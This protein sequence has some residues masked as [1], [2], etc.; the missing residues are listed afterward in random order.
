MLLKFTIKFFQSFKL[1]TKN[2]S[3]FIIW[4]KSIVTLAWGF[5]LYAMFVSES[6]LNF[7]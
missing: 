2:S 1:V 7:I 3:D 5:F 4:G 6:F